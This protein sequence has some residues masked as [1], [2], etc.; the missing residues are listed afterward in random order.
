MITADMSIVIM[1]IL[2]G[3]PT[4]GCSATIKVVT[5]FNM[6]S[7]K[8]NLTCFNR[9]AYLMKPVPYGTFRL[10]V[11]QPYTMQKTGIFDMNTKKALT[12]QNIMLHYITWMQ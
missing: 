6:Y 8:N 12:M 4:V 1:H 10:S 5:H 2:E 3:L 9:K 11:S 7:I